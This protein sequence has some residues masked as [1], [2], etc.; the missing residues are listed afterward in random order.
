M[1]VTPLIKMFVL[2]LDGYWVPGANVLVLCSV[3]L[4]SRVGCSCAWSWQHVRLIEWTELGLGALWIR[5]SLVEIS[6]LRLQSSD[7]SQA[8]LC[9]QYSVS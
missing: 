2:D 8:T 5:R 7:H 1:Q 6:V 9:P 3:H 4:W